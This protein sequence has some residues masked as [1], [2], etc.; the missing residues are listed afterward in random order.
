MKIKEYKN[1]YATFERLSPS[2]M[3]LIQLY[4]GSELADKMRCDTYK[5]A[6]EYF[7]AFAK[8]AKNH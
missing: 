3:Y 5:A 4:K 7:Q 1:G 2:G 6:T 8:I